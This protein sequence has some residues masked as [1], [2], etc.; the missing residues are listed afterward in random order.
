V[1]SNRIELD[2]LL[3]DNSKKISSVREILKHD[4]KSLAVFNA[5]LDS[6]YYGIHIPLEDMQEGNQYYPPD[7]INL[8]DYEVFVDCGAYDGGNVL[9][10][11]RR[12]ARYEYIYSFEPDPFQY[13]YTKHILDYHNTEFCELFNLGIYST[14]CEI[15]FHLD[16]AV[17]GSK[18][19]EDGEIKVSVT[20]LD[21]L[22]LSK[23][24][25]PTFIK[26]D[27]E[28]AELEALKGAYET[29]KHNKPKLA[30]CVYHGPTHIFDVPYWIKTNFPDYKI[31]LRQHSNINETVCYAVTKFTKNCW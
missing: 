20:S 5:K 23:I 13:E 29:I 30:I 14:E 15:S 26:M 19:K 12:T 17:G 31:Y 21:K 1:L 7:I 24:H 27:I 3:N 9:D 11:I 28:G 18:I 10:F 16:S 4:E 2:N 22:L 25:R 8:S 6:K